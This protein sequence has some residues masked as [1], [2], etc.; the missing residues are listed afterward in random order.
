MKDAVDTLSLE[1]EEP[2]GGVDSSRVQTT[3][4][5]RLKHA[6]IMMIDD[7]PLT[8]EALQIFLEEVGYHNFTAV[9]DSRHA[10]RLLAQ[11]QPDVVLLDLVM[12]HVGGFEILAQLRT[13]L[14]LKYLPVIVLT[15]STDADTKL[16]AL[17]L[18]AND[19]LAKPVDPSELVL[20]LRNTLAAKFYQDGLAYYDG[21]TSLP[22]RRLFMERTASAVK[23]AL[24]KHTICAILYVDLDHFNEFNDTLGL[25]CGDEVLKQ[26][27]E[28][29][30]ASTRASDLV[31]R[32]GDGCRVSI[33]RT[34]GD[35]FSILLTELSRYEDAVQVAQRVLTTMA[36]P[37][38]IANHELFIT[39][40]IGIALCPDDGADR[41]ALLEHADIA[42]RHAKRQGK[43]GYQFY[44]KVL[45]AKSL[46]RLSLINSLRK[47]IGQ[48]EFTLAYQPKVEVE[49]GCILGCEG[50]LRWLHPE[51][52]MVPPQKF[53]PLAEESGLIID[54]G[55][56]VLYRAC[57]QL[58]HWHALGFDRLRLA[59]NLSSQQFRHTD[60]SYTLRRA[61]ETTGVNPTYL[62]LEITES[63]I[64]ENAK[65]NID[66]LYRIKDM[67]V[68]LAIDDFGTGYSSLSYLKRFPL[69]ELKIDRSFIVG[70]PEE[71]DAALI[72]SAIIS[73]AHGLG[74]QVVAEGVENPE[75]LAFLRQHGCDEYQGYLFSKPV[76]APEF[77]ALLRDK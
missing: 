28:R 75:Q 39:A 8:L 14:T 7:E 65:D 64:M 20:R 1:S 50:L 54:I 72:A 38:C 70:I 74:L 35:E 31:A 71:K 63:M 56:W 41:D 13:E 12:P 17:E 22:N 49:T 66:V 42:M 24:D 3:A 26:V 16:Q 67:G 53:I 62:I 43:N 18:G 10:L 23:H 25:A 15:S 11:N 61:L 37:F 40:S 55:E 29:L 58:L 59:I 47:A 2:W 6:N 48:G 52:G 60:F 46:E 5:D 19:F 21:L 34:G 51:L 69:D 57:E 77:T 76:F 45:N 27:A 33:A 4:S 68:T 44:S 32:L 73:L 30:E 36:Q 9:S